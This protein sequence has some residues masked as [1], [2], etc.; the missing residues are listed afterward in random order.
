MITI[1]DHV[2][3]TPAA[4]VI[5]AEGFVAAKLEAEE[6]SRASPLSFLIARY[7]FTVGIWWNDS[8]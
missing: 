1:I 3:V 2:H 6:V 8:P 4:S 5:D 7:D